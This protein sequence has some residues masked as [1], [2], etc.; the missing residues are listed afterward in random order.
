MKDALLGI[1]KDDGSTARQNADKI[2]QSASRDIKVLRR[3]ASVLLGLTVSFWM[4]RTVGRM[5]V[6]GVL[7]LSWMLSS[8]VWQT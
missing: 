7:I 5:F 2:V 6:V 4:D 3:A 1:A 8:A